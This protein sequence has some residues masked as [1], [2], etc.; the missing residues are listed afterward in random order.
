MGR[1]SRCCHR[2]RWCDFMLNSLLKI[3]NL[4]AGSKSRRSI[5]NGYSI[6]DESSAQNDGCSGLEVRKILKLLTVFVSVMI[7]LMPATAQKLET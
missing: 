2:N 7:T 6:N 3:M 4:S 1:R 5:Y